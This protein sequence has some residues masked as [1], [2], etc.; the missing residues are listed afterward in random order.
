MSATASWH[1]LCPPGDLAG[2]ARMIHSYEGLPVTAAEPCHAAALGEALESY[3]AAGADTPELLRRTMEADPEHLMAPCMMAYLLKLAGTPANSRRA[4]DVHR[5]LAERV[6]AGAGTDWER[7][8]VAALGLWLADDLHTLMTRFEA[9]VEAYPTDLLALRMLHYLYFYDGDAAAMRDSVAR[10]LADYAGHP[11]AGYVNGMYAFGLEEA[12][13]YDEAE[14]Y[15]R[16]AVEMN[17]ADLWATHAVAHV[18]EMQRRSV[19]GVAW[20]QGLRP[21]WGEAN[22]FR[23]HLEWH[24]ALYHLARGDT[25]AALDL[26]DRQVGPAVADDFYLDVCNAASLLA[27]LEAAGVDVGPRWL[28]LAQAAERHV[29]DTELV[30]ASLHYLMPLLVTGSPAAGTLLATLERWAASGT[31]QGRVVQD[32]ALAVAR[33]LVARQQGEHARAEALFQGFRHTLVRIG[34]SHAQ[35]DLFRILSTEPEETP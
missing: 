3:L 33:F 11:L 28:P 7:G 24:E 26:Y 2:E 5:H 32:V 23:Y 4:G 27:R 22:N 16:L 20:L 13:D 29:E 31:A 6:A 9:L 10:R 14:R 21:N 8:H 19:E 1:T 35:R 15:G 34:G 17:P 30:F 12:G 18:L 25:D